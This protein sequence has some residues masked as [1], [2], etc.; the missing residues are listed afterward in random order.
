MAGLDEKI[1]A[2]AEQMMKRPLSD[3]EQLE[4]FRISEAAGMRDVQSFLY[5][6][7]VFKL[8]EDTMRTQFEK[9]VS[10]EGRLNEK[11]DEI[12]ALSAQINGTLSS[13][14][15]RILGEGAKR[16]GGAMGDEIASRSK[17]AMSSVNEF[18]TIR[19]YIVAASVTGISSTLA[20]WFGLSGVLRMDEINGPFRGVLA[21]PVG[22]WMF[23]CCA[24][25]TYFWCFDNW[26]K[27]KRFAFYKWLLALQ[28]VIMA[29]LLIS[30]L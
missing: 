25:Y 29:I 2:M 18:H 26:K 21:L 24:A 13:S 28:G 10:F 27:V 12:G 14:I 3:E 23:F 8:N 9:L 11:F 7:L 1:S 22:W 20:Y 16:I 19:G 30:M 17:E 4:I 15:E 6:L 5:L